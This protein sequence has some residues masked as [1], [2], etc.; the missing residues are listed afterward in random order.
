MDSGD[1]AK[2]K[3][4][5][6]MTMGCNRFPSLETWASDSKF[7]TLMTYDGRS[8]TCQ[9]AVFS[10]AT[11]VCAV[12]KSSKVHC[13]ND[14]TTS[15]TDIPAPPAQTRRHVVWNTTN[16][17]TSAPAVESMMKLDVRQKSQRES[18]WMHRPSLYAASNT[19]E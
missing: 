16:P 14:T 12:S 4:T 13:S 3:P 10:S 11:C 6:P 17:S 5:N 9:P 2:G 15:A 19:I 8:S 7:F 18:Q 1:V